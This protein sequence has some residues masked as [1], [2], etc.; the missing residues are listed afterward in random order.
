MKA[1]CWHGKRRRARRDA[2]PNPQILNRRDAIVR[3]TATAICGSD[4]HLYDGFIPT[5][6]NG[7]ILGHEFMGEVVALGSE[8]ENL[9][10]RRPRGGAVHDRLRPVL[11]LH[12]RALV[13]VRQLEPERRDRR[14]A[15]RLLAVGAVR[16]LAPLRRVR[17]RP[18]R[19]R[20]RAVRRRRADARCPTTSPTSRRCFS[21]TS[22][23]P[24]YMAAE[25]CNIRPGDTVAVW[26][27]GP[28]GL[29]AIKCA[30]LLGAERVIAIDA[31]RERLRIAA[32][33]C[34]A[35]V[36]RASRARTT[37]SSGSP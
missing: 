23:R 13:A 8:V 11:L 31:E 14:E 27:C 6:E 1:V 36:D 3:V 33:E 17:R 28:V 20:A 5:M 24:A 35:D 10:R 12:A 16:L 25:N 2:C 18:G 9:A 19:V 15:V 21:P 30:Y 37:S 4:L 22:C 29:F 32:A 26:G 34:K 7:D